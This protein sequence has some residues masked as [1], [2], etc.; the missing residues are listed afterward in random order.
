VKPA[1][2]GGWSGPSLATGIFAAVYH[3]KLTGTDLAPGVTV[4]RN[5]APDATHTYY[6][7][8]GAANR[9]ALDATAHVTG[10]NG[11]ALYT[12]MNPM[13]TDMYSGTSTLPS[14]CTWEAHGAAAIPGL[15]FIQ[16]FRPAGATCT[17]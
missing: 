13:L 2:I 10:V 15:V 9:T 8:A 6:F 16:T 4:T 12:I 5:G 1:T 17:P 14:G 11:T 7:G 3:S